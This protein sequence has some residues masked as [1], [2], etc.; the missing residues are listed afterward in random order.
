MPGWLLSTAVAMLSTASLAGAPAAVDLGAPSSQVMA[1]LGDPLRAWSLPMCSG[2]RL[3]MRRDRSLWLKLVFGTDEQLLAAGIFQL[4]APARGR[5][6]AALRWNGL[7]PGAPAHDAYPA[8]TTAWRPWLWSQGAK[9]WLWLERAEQGGPAH[10][11]RYLGGVVVSDASGFAAGRDF[12]YDVAEAV[13]STGLHGDDL[14]DAAFARPLLAWR[15]RTPPN[16]YLEV[17]SSPPQGANCDPASL[18][19]LDYTDLPRSP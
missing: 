6:R 14:R 1:R 16:A 18:V 3:E 17:L 15:Q 9:Q 5:P 13:V 19:Q 4:A 11:E 7:V 12:P 2:Y 10:R 8:L